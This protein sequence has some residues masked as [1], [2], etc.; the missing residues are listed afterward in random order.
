MQPIHDLVFC[1]CVPRHEF[2]G[3]ALQRW[4]D[5]HRTCPV[6]RSPLVDIVIAEVYEPELYNQLRT[7]NPR[8]QLD[9]LLDDDND[10]DTSEPDLIL[11]NDAPQAQGGFV[12]HRG[13]THVNVVANTMRRTPEIAYRPALFRQNHIE[14]AFDGPETYHHAIYADFDFYRDSANRALL[15]RI[16]ERTYRR[17]LFVNDLYHVSIAMGHREYLLTDDFIGFEAF[18][19]VAHNNGVIVRNAYT[20]RFQGDSYML[21]SFIK[22]TYDARNDAGVVLD[23]LM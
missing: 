2:E 18:L 1:Q 20:Y 9:D 10:S 13:F 3:A 21:I 17:F 4:F 15:R 16:F 12:P 11:A 7:E 23:E 14:S 5:L 8:V 19:R 6:S 22:H